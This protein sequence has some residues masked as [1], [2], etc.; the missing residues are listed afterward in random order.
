[1]LSRNNDEHSQSLLQFASTG[2]V[3]VE[4]ELDL[5]ER[6]EVVHHDL[7]KNTGNSEPPIGRSSYFAMKKLPFRGRRKM[8]TRLTKKLSKTSKLV[9]LL[10]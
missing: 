4:S 3:S 2:S 7:V 1:M 8:K 5:P 9:Q 6:A 10:R